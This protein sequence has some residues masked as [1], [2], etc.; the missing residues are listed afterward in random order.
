MELSGTVSVCADVHVDVF[1]GQRPI[2][3]L[4]QKLIH[5]AARDSSPLCVECC[6]GSAACRLQECRFIYIHYLQQVRC[7]KLLAA[8]D[9]I[10]IHIVL[11]HICIPA[12]GDDQRQDVFILIFLP[13]YVEAGQ[14]DLIRDIFEHA[15]HD[16]AVLIGDSLVDSLRALR[17]G[18]DLGHTVSIVPAVAHAVGI[19]EI[20]VIQFRD[21]RRF[22]RRV[23]RFGL[24]VVLFVVLIVVCLVGCR[25]AG[26]QRKKH[27]CGQQHGQNL[28]HSNIPLTST[29][30]GP[31]RP[32]CTGRL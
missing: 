3:A 20:L 23:G 31:Q 22:I 4:R 12:T 26:G 25:A 16:R 21:L 6:S 32:P 5:I 1:I 27:C 30:T 8:G 2:A 17:I 14:A 11:V 18:F 7:G 13:R 29:R 15:I 24:M 28:F 9:V 10:Q 19:V